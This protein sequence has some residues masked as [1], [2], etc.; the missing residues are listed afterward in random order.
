MAGTY[1]VF[2]IDNLLLGIPYM[3]DHVGS[4]L[5]L[6]VEGPLGILEPG[7]QEGLDGIILGELAVKLGIL[8]EVADAAIG[9]LLDDGLDGL[10]DGG[11]GGLELLDAFVGCLG[12]GGLVHFLTAT[13]T[14]YGLRRR[15]LGDLALSPVDAASSPAAASC[16]AGSAVDGS[17]IGRV[18]VH[19]PVGEVGRLVHGWGGRGGCI[20]CCGDCGMCRVVGGGGEVDGKRKGCGICEIRAAVSVLLLLLLVLELLMLLLLLRRRR[21][22]RWQACRLYS[23]RMANLLHGSIQT[24]DQT[25]GREG[26]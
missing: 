22:W 16:R 23:T 1:I 25:G 10:G 7:A 26:G 24:R 21:R 5:T 18:V 12:A 20:C 9:Y 13:T 6:K 2:T 17:I 14:G 19:L 15:G 11:E 3:L 8:E 4:G